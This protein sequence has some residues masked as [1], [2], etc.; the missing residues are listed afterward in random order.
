MTDDKQAK[1]KSDTTFKLPE[2]IIVIT[3]ATG[4]LGSALVESLAAAGVGQLI[5]S[6][7]KNLVQAELLLKRALALGA[8]NVRVIAADL[9]TEDGIEAL[10]LAAGEGKTPVGGFV[11]LA[12]INPRTPLAE[13]TRDKLREAAAIDLEAALLLIKGLLPMM[14]PEASIVLC[15]SRAAHA[16]LP[17]ILPYSAAKT[18]LIGAMANLVGELGPKGVRI[19]MIEPGL[20]RRVSD[21]EADQLSEAI[22]LGRI[23]TPADFAAVAHFLLSRGSA[24]ITGQRLAVSGGL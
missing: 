10:L 20:I 9:A 21:A 15:G 12:G 3:G 4:Q 1:H 23:G 2:G 8:E 18:G 11:H 24:Y 5:L 6:C 16:P 13:L 7:R 17:K 19:N 22:P 14:D